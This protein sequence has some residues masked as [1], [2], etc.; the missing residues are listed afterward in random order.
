MALPQIGGVRPAIE[1]AGLAEV[2]VRVDEA[3]DEPGAARVDTAGALRDG[4]ARTRAGAG[5]AAVS[6]DDRRIGH[7]G[8][9]GAV[10][11]RGAG[12]SDIG[13]RSER[14]GIQQGEQEGECED[15]DR[16]GHAWLPVWVP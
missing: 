1:P 14:P 6:H 16:S 8:G 5:D 3:G 13:L 9:T 10:E 4:A 11:E 12:D 7:G 2:H 15:G